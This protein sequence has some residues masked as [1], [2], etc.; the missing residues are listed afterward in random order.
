VRIS[1][2]E[3]KPAAAGAF[4]V[5]LTVTNAGLM[6]TALEIAKRVKIVRPDTCAIELAKGRS[7]CSRRRASRAPARRS[8]SGG[9]NPVRPGRELDRKGSGARR[10]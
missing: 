4:D 1:A 7:W 2:V 10:R 9:S 5:R 6:P 8:R 3:A